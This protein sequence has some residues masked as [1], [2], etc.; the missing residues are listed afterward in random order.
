MLADLLGQP[1]SHF[2]DGKD[3]GG[4]CIVPLRD[5][6]AVLLS[7]ARDANFRAIDPS[8]ESRFM[9]ML[10]REGD[11]H[12]PVERMPLREGYEPRKYPQKVFY[13]KRDLGALSFLPIDRLRRL[14]NLELY[15]DHDYDLWWL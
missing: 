13:Q 9:E 3:I 12:I 14:P 1:Y 8:W 11:I 2:G 4:H 7:W 6:L 10:T 15:K 5:P